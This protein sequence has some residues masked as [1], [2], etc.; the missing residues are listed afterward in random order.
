MGQ[1]R[2][3]DQPWPRDI[4]KPDVSEPAAPTDGDEAANTETQE[5][6][7]DMATPDGNAID[8]AASYATDGK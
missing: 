2:S 7:E 6:K 4:E 1:R 8:G 3:K 5:C